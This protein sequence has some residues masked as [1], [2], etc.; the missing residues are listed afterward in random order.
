MTDASGCEKKALGDTDGAVDDVKD[1]EQVRPSC[2]RCVC[3]KVVNLI[4]QH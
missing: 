1:T 4:L 2:R 3:V